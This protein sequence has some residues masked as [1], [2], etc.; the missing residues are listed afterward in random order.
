MKTD[1]AAKKCAIET[2]AFEDGYN[3]GKVDPD[4]KVNTQCYVWH[5]NELD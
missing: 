3:V 4:C 5:K 1:K 2:E